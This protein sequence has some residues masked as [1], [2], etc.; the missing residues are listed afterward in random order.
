[1]ESR[2]RERPP[3]ILPDGVD[4]Q[5]MSRLPDSIVMRQGAH[6]PDGA[7]PGL[8]GG[9]AVRRAY[10]GDLGAARAGKHHLG[11]GIDHN[12]LSLPSRTDKDWKIFTGQTLTRTPR[13]GT[14]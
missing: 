8:K 12:H 6:G 11:R 1:M 5:M 7:S 13:M 9:E 14:H 10:L 2:N 3:G 4:E